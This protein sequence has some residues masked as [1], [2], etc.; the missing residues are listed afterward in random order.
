MR[1]SY[2]FLAANVL[3]ATILLI[4]L[5]I[6]SIP[7]SPAPRQAAETVRT[8]TP[9]SAP[10]VTFGN[11]FVGPVD[12]PVTIVE[13]GDYLCEPCAQMEGPLVA[14]REEF[15]DR[16]RIVWKDFPNAALHPEA[17]NAAIAARCA[18][19]QGTFWEYRQLLLDRQASVTSGSYVPFAAELGLDV[20]G[21]QDCLQARRPEPLVERDMEEALRL[22]VDGAP[23]IFINDDRYSGALSVE[24]LRGLVQAELAAAGEATAPAETF[25]PE[26]AEPDEENP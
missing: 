5:G 14:I 21:F 10:T 26:A 4:L 13:F 25:A 8:A 2:A 17:V 7:K 3:L 12:A 9:L 24:Q 6:S 11:P 1:Q 23:Y 15:P 22:R 19:E 16:V 18:D 20:D